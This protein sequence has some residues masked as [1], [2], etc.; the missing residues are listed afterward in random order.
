MSNPQEEQL[1]RL[2]LNS[3]EFQ[4]NLLELD[5]AE[6]NRVL[7]TLKKLLKLDWGQ[8]YRD[9]G[10]KWEKI[11]SIRAPKGIDAVYSLRITQARRATALR[12]GQFLR[13]LTIQ[14]DHDAT[15]GRK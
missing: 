9:P 1:V 6:R 15:Y 2:D 8:V 12:E 3:P 11:T 5:K 4:K 13:F 14:P 10:L 7:D